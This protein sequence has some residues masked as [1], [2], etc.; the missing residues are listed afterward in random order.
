MYGRTT[1][2]PL[3]MPQSMHYMRNWN[4]P[5]RLREGQVL[6][7]RNDP[8]SRA[9][10]DSLQS[11]RLAARA[12]PRPPAAEPARA[13]ATTSTAAVLVPPLKGRDRPRGV[14]AQRDHAAADAMYHRGIRRTR[15]CARSTANYCRSTRLP[16]GAGISMRLVLDREPWGSCAAAAHHERSSPARLTGTRSARRRCVAACAGSDESRKGFLLNT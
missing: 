8:V 1:A 10:R 3:R 7:Q 14:P 13:L 9:L 11:F 15:G 2:C 12:R 16:Q 4:R 5:T 6:A